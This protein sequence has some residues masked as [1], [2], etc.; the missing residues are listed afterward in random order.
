[1]YKRQLKEC[2]NNRVFKAVGAAYSL[3]ELEEAELAVVQALELSDISYGLTKDIIRNRVIVEIEKENFK[4]VSTILKS[5]RQ[6]NRSI[7]LRKGDSFFGELSQITLLPD[8]RIYGN[9][10]V[11]IPQLFGSAPR[12]TSGYSVIQNKTSHDSTAPNLL[13]G[14]TTAGHCPNNVR[15][16][17]TSQTIQP[18]GELDFQQN[19]D[20]QWHRNSTD[21]YAARVISSASDPARTQRIGWNVA[22]SVRVA[23]IPMGKYT[24]KEGRITGNTCGIYQGTTTSTNNLNNRSIT[25]GIVLGMLGDNGDSGGPVFGYSLAGLEAYGTSSTIR[26]SSTSL[27]FTTVDSFDNLGLTILTSP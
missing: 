18:P 7:R 20:L 11:S 3:D 15:V 24:C 8:P 16:L 22:R 14:I 10:I 4:E 2:T 6:R 5:V 1:M 19:T 23:N 17:G 26:R 25:S 12:C 9:D 27:T 21:E 13:T